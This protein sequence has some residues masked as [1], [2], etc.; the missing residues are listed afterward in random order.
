MRAEQITPPH[1]RRAERTMTREI[2]ARRA[3]LLQRNLNASDWS[4]KICSF[5]DWLKRF[6]GCR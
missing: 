6:I 1:D 4:N 3:T 2:V 5:A